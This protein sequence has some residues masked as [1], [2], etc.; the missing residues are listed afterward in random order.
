MER[1]H[2]K[3]LVN[4]LQGLIHINSFVVLREAK[5]NI[6]QKGLPVGVETEESR[7]NIANI[8][9]KL[10]C[11]DAEDAMCE[12]RFTGEER[13]RDN[14]STGTVWET[15]HKHIENRSKELC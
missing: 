4:W 11:P 3:Q 15:L 7:W 13:N 12:P 1:K 2:L 9:I 5:A 6:T 8:A 10:F 14:S